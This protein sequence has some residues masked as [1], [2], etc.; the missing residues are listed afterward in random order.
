MH[1]WLRGWTET[2][3]ATGCRMPK[4]SYNSVSQ[5]VVREALTAGNYCFLVEFSKQ[6]CVFTSKNLLLKSLLFLFIN[7]SSEADYYI[8]CC[9]SSMAFCLKFET[10]SY[11]F[12]LAIWNSISKEYPNNCANNPA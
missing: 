5:T 9:H 12:S 6:K 10:N 8:I 1:Y 3:N 7:T 11:Y 2:G 4:T